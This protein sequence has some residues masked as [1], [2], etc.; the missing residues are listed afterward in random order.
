MKDFL[1][2]KF[3]CECLGC[4]ICK[5]QIEIPGGL[6]YE[7]ENVTLQQDPENPIEGFLIVNIKRHVNSI[8][9]LSKEERNELIE[10]INMAVQALKDLKITDEV[11]IVQ[12]ER[13]K[14]L[15]VWIFPKHEWMKEKF[16]SG[17]IKYLRDISIY[18]QEHASDKDIEEVMHTIEK[19]KGY[20]NKE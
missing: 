20:F 13:S 10:V 11:T 16:G 19:L 14:H 2:N 18:A 4:A 5:H 15:H 17:I 7:S 9:D 6:I 3:E 12:E 1:G 8:N